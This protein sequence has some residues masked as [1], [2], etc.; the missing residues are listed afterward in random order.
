MRNDRAIAGGSQQM[1]RVD[2]AVDVVGPAVEKNDRGALG[3][4]EL[5]ISDVQ[6][7]G[8]DLPERAEG[9]LGRGPL[10]GWIRVAARLRRRGARD[11]QLGS[12]G[13]SRGG[14]EQ[15]APRKG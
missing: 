1:R 13:R 8:V 7:A 5:G 6:Q 12:G 10:R 11:T 4:T 2:V 15:R 14:G 9:R 3:R